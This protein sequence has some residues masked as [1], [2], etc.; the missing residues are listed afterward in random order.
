MVLNGSTR[1]GWAYY[2]DFYFIL[3]V[4]PSHVANNTVGER[5]NMSLPV[6]YTQLQTL[7]ML[8]SRKREYMYLVLKATPMKATH[9][10][11]NMQ[12]FYNF[13]KAECW[14][15]SL[16]PPLAQHICTFKRK[17]HFIQKKGGRCIF[18]AGLIFR[19]YNCA[20]LPLYLVSAINTKKTPTLYHHQKWI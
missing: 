2:Q 8:P 19:D 15:S 3:L 20:A 17:R 18:M 16:L 12:W 5:Y 14:S 1:R 11:A 4:S 10:Y 7:C 6:L 13:V 9:R